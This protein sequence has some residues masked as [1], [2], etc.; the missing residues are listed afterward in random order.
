MLNKSNFFSNFF[1]NSKNFYTNLKNTKK[2]FK[3][4]ELDIKNC[5]IP[6]LQSYDKNYIFDF[7]LAT[8]R[9]FSKYDKGK[10]KNDKPDTLSSPI[11]IS[12]LELTEH[13]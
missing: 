7:K 8:I 9:K 6:L 2:I 1:L 13:K 4:F 11:Q 12:S 10:V 3:S 5:E